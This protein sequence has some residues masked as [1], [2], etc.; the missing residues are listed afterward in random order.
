MWLGWRL[1]S[2]RSRRRPV[3]RAQVGGPAVRPFDSHQAA[4]RGGR[5]PARWLAGWLLICSW[6]EFTIR[7]LLYNVVA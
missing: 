4:G 5:R 1:R 2:P 3:R 6:L 7:K